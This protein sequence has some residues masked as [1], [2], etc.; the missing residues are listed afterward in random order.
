MK[1]L[2]D[3]HLLLWV[4]GQPQLLSKN[5]QAILE[6][7]KNQLFFSPASLWEIVIKNGLGRSDF[8]VNARLLRRALIDNGYSELPINSEHT[9]AVDSL[10]SIHKDPFDRILI[11]Q[12]LVE[13]IVL[14]TTDDQV[15]QYPGPI[16][17][18]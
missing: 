17:K 14:L 3:T 2:L 7:E 16:Q 4:A 11:A 13:G 8:Q 5:A 9:L 18:V 12:A 10:A 6:L 1:F 15:A